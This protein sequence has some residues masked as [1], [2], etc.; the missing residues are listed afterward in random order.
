MRVYYRFIRHLLIV[1]ISLTVIFGL[2]IV[3]YESSQFYQDNLSYLLPDN[4]D[5]YLH[6]QKPFP[7]LS[8]RKAAKQL[9]PYLPHISKW[10]NQLSKLEDLP[11]QELVW[12]YDEDAGIDGWLVLSAGKDFVL[13]DG[14]VYLEKPSYFQ[15]EK[16][17]AAS[18]QRVADYLLDSVDTASNLHQFI[19][20]RIGK[21]RVDNYLFI[22]GKFDLSQKIG[23]FGSS[24]D[25]WRPG[26]RLV[27]LGDDYLYWR[28]LSEQKSRFSWWVTKW[29]T[30]QWVRSFTDSSLL[31]YS[32]PAIKLLDILPYSG[33]DLGTWQLRWKNKY[34]ISLKET[35]QMFDVIDLAVVTKKETGD[36]WQKGFW[37]Q[38]DFSWLA[39][40]EWDSGSQVMLDRLIAIELGY[41]YP[42][43][44]TV[45]L[46]DN[47][48]AEVFAATPKEFDYQLFSYG[49]TRGKIIYFD[50]K[51]YIF[52][53]PIS[54]QIALVGNDASLLDRF[55]KPASFFEIPCSLNKGKVKSGFWQRNLWLS[56]KSNFLA[57]FEVKQGESSDFIVCF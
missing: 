44:T 21:T 50:D 13:P 9:Q 15:G 19:Q 18:S 46:P 55:Y 36:V 30:P 4:V 56:I 34:G 3:I 38:R 16:V 28:G 39:R 47:S 54:S 25:E 26:D 12:F 8:S 29:G 33:I 23:Y 17:L 1:L 31:I 6:L 40:L 53:L 45:K 24:L 5:I 52:I 37:R 57:V 10:Q 43:L 27:L 22:S 42:T 41:L 32:L 48:Q 7:L 2:V 49:K 14:F 51:S 11:W 35:L 20:S